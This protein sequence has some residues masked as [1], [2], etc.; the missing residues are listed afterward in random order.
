MFQILT[1]LSRLQ[2]NNNNVFA[3]KNYIVRI[4]IIHTVMIYV[5]SFIQLM[6]KFDIARGGKSKRQEFPTVYCT[7]NALVAAEPSIPVS[8]LVDIE[9]NTVY[10]C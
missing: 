3:I 7:L 5:A 2:N 4:L 10:C 6:L 1:D 8:E 9:S